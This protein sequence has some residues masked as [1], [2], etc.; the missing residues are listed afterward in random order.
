MPGP[1]VTRSEPV[2]ASAAGVPPPGEPEPAARAVVRAFAPPGPERHAVVAW[3]RRPAGRTGHVSRPE[4]H[5]N[6]PF[7]MAALV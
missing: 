3:A 1:P 5:R 2:A 7:E 6:R 4:Q